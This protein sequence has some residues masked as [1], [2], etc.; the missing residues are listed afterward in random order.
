MCGGMLTF[1]ALAHVF[2]ATQLVKLLWGGG[3]INALCTCA[4]GRCYATAEADG[5]WGGM[6]MFFALTHTCSMLGNRAV[7][8]HSRDR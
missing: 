6:L 4:H 3:D 2:N 5:R 7:L 8:S 1:L